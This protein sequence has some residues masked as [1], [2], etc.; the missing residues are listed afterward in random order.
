MI[1]RNNLLGYFM[2][3]NA[4]VLEKFVLSQKVNGLW[5]DIFLVKVVILKIMEDYITYN[6]KIY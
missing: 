5:Q 4:K 3:V 1:Q 6:N 2:G